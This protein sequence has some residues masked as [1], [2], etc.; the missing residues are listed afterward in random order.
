M[1]ILNKTGLKIHPEKSGLVPTHRLE[2]LG[3]EID[4]RD[5]PMF[6]VP[7]SK[8]KDILT[9]INSMKETHKKNKPVHARRLASLR[10]SLNFLMAAVLPTRMLLRAMSNVLSRIGWDSW[11][12][13]S[14]EIVN[15]LTWWEHALE[16]WN[17]R[18]MIP[19][20]PDLTLFT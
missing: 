20:N 16:N 8:K 10:G 11:I 12:R 4:A 7:E 1:E 3:L 2:F 18:L 13:L 14:Q 5:K 9:K 17:G 15:D 6:R 19:E